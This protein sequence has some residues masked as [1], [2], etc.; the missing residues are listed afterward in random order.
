MLV[1]Y[2]KDN[3]EKLKNEVKSN[4][5]VFIAGSPN[6]GRKYVI[7]EWGR[8]QKNVCIIQLEK[9]SI[10]G[11]Y[12]SLTI[13]LKEVF[14]KQKLKCSLSPEISLSIQEGITGI[15]LG[16]S[17]KDD[18]LFEEE[19][20]IYSHLNKLMQRCNV[21]FIVDTS[22]NITDGSVEIIDSFIAK[23]NKQRFKSNDCRRSTINIKGI[24]YINLF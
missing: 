9:T 18:L 1:D 16:V 22:L 20:N 4:C 5:N 15:S 13:K 17:K 3:L 8:T 24:L 21:I 10:Q 12:A 2:Q 23:R 7:K 14:E 11:R 6:S 19:K